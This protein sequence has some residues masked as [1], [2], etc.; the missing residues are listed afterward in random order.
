M[1]ATPW[2]DRLAGTPVPGLSLPG[3]DGSKVDLAELSRGPLVAYLYPGDSFEQGDGAARRRRASRRDSRTSTPTSCAVQRAGFRE[4]A[5]EFAALGARVLGIS[6]E[7]NEVQ[8]AVALTERLPF[9][10]CSDPECRLADA[11]SLPTLTDLDQRRYRRL[12]LIC[13]EGIVQTAFYPVSPK[14]SAMQALVWLER[15]SAR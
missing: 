6:A 4:Y 14:R 8:R 7:P 1:P 5:L 13:R 2:M 15:S 10:L 11:L 12:T 9:P 3:S